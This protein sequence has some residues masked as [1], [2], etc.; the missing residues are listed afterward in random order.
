[1]K[2]F[3]H[4]ELD[5]EWNRLLP[6]GILETRNPNDGQGFDPETKSRYQYRIERGIILKRH[7]P[8]AGLDEWLDDPEASQWHAQWHAVELPPTWPLLRAYWEFYGG[9]ILARKDSDA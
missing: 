5:G 3:K 9:T 1:M 4:P 6:D 2:Q 7:L 8:P